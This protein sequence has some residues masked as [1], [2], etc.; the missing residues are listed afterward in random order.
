MKKNIKTFS[1]FLTD[2]KKNENDKSVKNIDWE[3]RKLKW[4]ASI[5]DLYNI[6]D[7]IIV[8]NLSKGGLPFTAKKEKVRLFEEYI[9][10]YDVENYFIKAG[11]IDIK[12]YPVGTIIIGAFGRVNMVLPKGTIKLVLQDWDNWRIVSGLGSEMKLIDFN[13]TNIVRLLQENI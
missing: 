4:I 10:N 2:I 1:E 5:D 3:A 7:E 12:L 13:E 8:S 11:R 6:V 9:G